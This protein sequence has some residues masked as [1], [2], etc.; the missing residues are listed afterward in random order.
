MPKPPRPQPTS[1]LKLERW[2]SPAT[3][4]S[5]RLQDV[6]VQVTA[7]TAATIENENIT[8]SNELAFLVPSVTYNFGTQARN[9]DISIRGIGTYVFGGAVEPSVATVVDGV[10]IAREGEYLPTL[11]DTAQVE[12][13][14]GPQGT[15]FGV[16]ASAGVVN[17]TTKNP[18]RTYG[19]TGIFIFD[20][21]N[22]YQTQGDVTGPITD[23]L[24]FRLS[25]YDDDRGGWIKD[26]FTGKTN[27]TREGGG[28]LKL[29]YD[30]TPAPKLHGH[31]LDYSTAYADCC[32]YQT[33]KSTNPAVLAA[34]LPVV[35]ST[36]NNLT[37]TNA[38]L[39]NKT[40][41][42]GVSLQ[43][44][45]QLGQYK[46]TSISA[47]RDELFHNNIDAD[48]LPSSSAIK[49]A[50]EA[51]RNGNGEYEG[52]PETEIYQYSQELRLTS[53][54]NERNE[55]VAGLYYLYLFD[56]QDGDSKTATCPTAAGVGVTAAQALVNNAAPT[57][58]LCPYAVPF[59]AV[60]YILYK[61]PTYAIYG[62][63]TFHLTSKLG[64]IL[65]LRGQ[66]EALSYSYYIPPTPLVPT[67]NLTKPTVSIARAMSE[68]FLSGKIGLQYKLTPDIL[69]YFTYSRG[70][71][72]GTFAFIQD[73]A[74]TCTPKNPANNVASSCTSDNTQLHTV[75]PEISDSYEIGVKTSLLN[76]KLIFNADAWYTNINGFQAQAFVPSTTGGVGVF[77]TVNA[78]LVRTSG[79]EGAL[80]TA[81]LHGFS[82]T[83][84]AA[85]VD[86]IIV[87]DPEAACYSNEPSPPC[88]ATGQDI[89]NGR[90]PN[91]PKEKFSIDV[92]WQGDTPGGG[93]HTF[94]D[95]AY[96]WQSDVQDT[97]AQDPLTIIPAYG[98]MNG[99]LAFADKSQHYNVRFF[100]NNIFNQSF[101]QALG[102]DPI[103][104]NTYTHFLP[105]EAHRYFGVELKADY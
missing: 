58:A 76:R 68:K 78:G 62:Q 103:Q 89:E 56:G 64:L 105:R 88:T 32:Q 38:Y 85:Y 23:K 60:T 82:G 77:S 80:S 29:Q 81:R 17:I 15:L 3:R 9:S 43:A 40:R 75:N 79:I 16:N 87:S 8:T 37:N 19:A 63:D 95:L 47:Y 22:D 36:T 61:S 50:T 1:Q 13:L 65:G 34:L 45:Y 93:F 41:D 101:V 26:V 66:S 14:E 71:K 5:E 91:S 24:L 86:A 39:Y 27:D 72:A 92:N 83:F 94:A 7:V 46:I 31:S 52:L 84:S 57:G 90:L 30:P 74:S 69:T 28:R 70:N 53:P 54:A 20:D 10:L 25:L 99:S 18:S 55:Y 100:V 97:L 98:L 12:V 51:V 21:G 2:S 33:D 48:G 102:P 59:S 35:P 6:P 73:V 42:W 104:A 44:D 96:V 4:R 11:N 67:D 49:G